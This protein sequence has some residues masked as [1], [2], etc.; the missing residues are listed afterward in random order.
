[1]PDPF[2]NHAKAIEVYAP[3]RAGDDMDLLRLEAL[4]P[5]EGGGYEV[6]IYREERILITQPAE[7]DQAPS[8]PQQ[9][10][11]VWTAHETIHSDRPTAEKALQQVLGFLEMRCR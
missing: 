4:R 11:R 5:P 7:D 6:V 1:V 2:L 8:A 10:R 9:E 3:L